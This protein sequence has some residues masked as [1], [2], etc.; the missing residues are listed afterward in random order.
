MTVTNQ[1]K[2]ILFT[3]FF[4]RSKVLGCDDPLTIFLEV[5]SFYNLGNNCLE[6]IRKSGLLTH[7]RIQREVQGDRTPPPP[8]TH[9]HK[10]KKIGFLS[11]TGPDPLYSHKATNPEF[12]V[13]PSSTRKLCLSCFLVCLLQPC[14]HLLGK[15]WPLGSLVCNV[16][17][18]FLLLSHVV[19]CV[20]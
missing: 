13:G 8:H 14:G 19:S 5:V 17:L 16:L 20:T 6:D 10:K 4:L 1:N 18:C 9:T 11:N 15:G 12:N 3:N 7:A 2:I